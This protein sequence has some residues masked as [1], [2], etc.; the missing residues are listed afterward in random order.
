MGIRQSSIPT[1]SSEDTTGAAK[2]QQTEILAATPP[3]ELENDQGERRTLVLT[4]SK[5]VRIGGVGLIHTFSRA[6]DSDWS[7]PDASRSALE[8]KA[9]EVAAESGGGRF[10]R[11]STSEDA[12]LRQLAARFFTSK[13][14]PDWERISA[15]LGR[16]PS[17]CK[18]HFHR[19]SK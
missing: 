13:G 14:F 16:T 4:G 18:S 1:P 6:D 5:R 2:E 3:P 15:E 7:E 17:A 19:G 8:D 11:W 9:G 10:A 12:L